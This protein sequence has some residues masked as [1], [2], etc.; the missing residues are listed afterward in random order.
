MDIHDKNLKNEDELKIMFLAFNLVINEHEI[1][2]HL[3]IGYQIYSFGEQ[4][5]DKYNSPKVKPELSSD[6]AKKRGDKESGEDIEIKIFG[7]VISDLTL[8]EALFI[9]NYHNYVIYD[10]DSFRIKI[11]KCN[12]QKISLDDTFLEYLK[13]FKINPENILHAENKRYYLNNL[14][15]KSIIN[16]EKFI[17]KRKRPINY[18]IDGVKKEDFEY[19]LNLLED[20]K[21]IDN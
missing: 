1:L 20:I 14:N 2:G 4:K 17:M 16:T 18:N 3:N 11:M 9:L 19:L 8:K 15:K 5:K 7:R 12:E 13:M 10:Y 21:N 6:Y